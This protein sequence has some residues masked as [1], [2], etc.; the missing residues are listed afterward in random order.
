MRWIRSSWCLWCMSHLALMNLDIPC[1]MPCKWS[2]DGHKKSLIVTSCYD[3]VKSLC[4][5]NVVRHMPAL[6]APCPSRCDA[7]FLISES[8]SRS[9]QIALA[10]W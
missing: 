4:S 7:H 5:T 10:Q 6:L 3:L 8:F 1:Y 2:I 9:V